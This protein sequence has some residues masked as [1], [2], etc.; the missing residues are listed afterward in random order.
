[1]NELEQLSQL[2]GEI[3]DTTLDASSWPQVIPAIEDFL[4][5]SAVNLFAQDALKKNANVF[6]IHGIEPAFVQSYLEKY[7]K[8]NPTFPAALFFTVGQVIR[9][10]DMMPMAEFR[11]TRFWKEWIAPQGIVDSMAV[12][13]EK[14][15]VSCAVFSVLR[16]ERD[17]L[18]DEEAY[19]RMCLLVPHVQ[20]AVL[21]GKAIDLAKVDAAALAD[22][23][24]GMAAGTILVDAEGRIVHVNASARTMLAEGEVVRADGARLGCVDAQ[25]ERS[26]REIFSAAGAGDSAVGTKGIAVPIAARDGKPHL[27]HV[28]PLT[29]GARRLAGVRYSAVAAVFVQDGTISGATV[30]ETIA[31]HYKLTPAE[32]RVMLGIVEIGGVPEIA[33]VLGVSENTVKTHLQ[34]VFEKTGTSRQA[35]LVKIVAGFMSP[36]GGP[37]AAQP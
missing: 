2:I 19:R 14:S 10:N 24:D 32:L 27:A 33:P 36:L 26:L 23:L 25:A 35:D 4:G 17:G 34:R 22:T 28:L 9:Q 21:I 1:M 11:Q 7:I 8:L 6:H 31:R 3:Y 30:F 13:L 37:P 15:A 16:H 20:R 12:I 18:V 29:S 5:V